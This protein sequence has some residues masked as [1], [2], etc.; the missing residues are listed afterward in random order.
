MED[1]RSDGRRKIERR[2]RQLE[3]F[4]G[5][6]GVER[7]SKRDRRKGDRRRS[8]RHAELPPEEREKKLHE[9]E[10]RSKERSRDKQ[11][12]QKRL[13]KELKIREDRRR[14]KIK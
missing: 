8:D 11:L 6:D 13:S 2:I 9:Y 14:D 7:R 10:H 5:W 1:R 4:E 3:P 12:K